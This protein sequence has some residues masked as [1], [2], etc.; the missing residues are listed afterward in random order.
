[1]LDKLI[2]LYPHIPIEKQEYDEYGLELGERLE[3][4]IVLRF[5]QL[6]EGFQYV[7]TEL[8]DYQKSDNLT[9][10]FFKRPRAAGGKSE[11]PTI[12]ISE[13]DLYVSAALSIQSKGMTKWLN[14]L[15]SGAEINPELN[16]L[17][18]CITKN[19][20]AILEEIHSYTKSGKDGEFFI[21]TLMI[22]GASIGRSRLFEEIRENTKVNRNKDFYTFKNKEYRIMNK[23]CSICQKQNVEVWGYVSIYNFYTAKTEL[24]P[25]SG[26]F[27]PK[28]AWKNYPCC[29]E[30][31]KK[32]EITCQ[33]VDEYLSFRF[34]SLNY[35]LI[36]EFLNDFHD[37]SGNEEVMDL[38]MDPDTA[39]LQFG[40]NH[41]HVKQIT[42]DKKEVLSLLSEVNS[43]ANFSL[44]FY[45][46]DQKK[47]SILQTIEDVFPDQ[48]KDVFHAKEEVEAYAIFKNISGLG[49]KGLSAD[50]EFSFAILRDFLP[51]NSKIY[52]DF[53]KSF[54]AITRSIVLQRKVDYS[55]LLHR[56]MVMIQQHEAE[57]DKK[58]HKVKKEEVGNLVLK[59]YMLL[60]FLQKLGC[61]ETQEIKSKEVMMGNRIA[62]FLEEHKFFFTTDAKKAVFLTGALCQNLLNIQQQE[63]GAQPFRKRL[64][65]LK[66]NPELVKRI[67]TES[68]EKLNQIDKNYYT[69]L[70][71]VIAAL[72]LQSNFKELSNDE[73]SFIFSLGMTLNKSLKEPKE[74]TDDTQA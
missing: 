29:P 22:D 39:L 74:G 65:S 59:A 25:L 69:E 1:M 36:P 16:K 33:F 24:A 55:F 28:E 30:C 11:F 21:L 72:F 53:T 58:K 19:Q 41:E 62:E 60:L 43:A 49:G 4:V 3:K 48:F 51:I 7:G 54:L 57:R 70:E 23:T 50:L 31:T 40:L 10:W 61:I 17:I 34:C 71:K 13:K 38:I 2:K 56:I 37:Q 68:I 35:F 5:S 8:R 63:R 15:Q 9:D 46:A 12:F 67:Y 18:H 27:K 20:A 64:N 45:A 14:I 52:G 47:F 26:G 42:E 73:I 66:L 6:Q 44:F 32:L